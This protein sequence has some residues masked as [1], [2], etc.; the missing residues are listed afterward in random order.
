MQDHGRRNGSMASV[1]EPALLQ[2]NSFNLVCPRASRSWWVS[3][4]SGVTVPVKPWKSLVVAWLFTVLAMCT[5]ELETIIADFWIICATLVRMFVS[6]VS[7]VR[8]LNVE[9]DRYCLRES[10][11][12]VADRTLLP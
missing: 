2:P 1:E 4:A 6:C 11:D 12:I 8:A 9:M 10:I 5:R 7:R 3:R